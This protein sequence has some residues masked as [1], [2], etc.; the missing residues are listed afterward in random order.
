MSEIANRNTILIANEINSI[1]EQTH[2]IMIL[3]SIEIGKR[4]VEAKAML[5]HGD[6]GKWLD[7]SVNYS[8]RT[9]NNLMKLYEEYGKGQSLE[10][11]N[12]SQAIAKLNYTQAVAL[13]GLPS[14]ER[15]EFIENNDIEKMST[16]ELNAAVKEKKQLE[17]QLKEMEKVVEKEKK[18]KEEVQKKFNSFRE[19]AVKHQ[20][21]IDNLTKKLK[22]AEKSG[23]DK[24]IKD[25]NSI[26]EKKESE[27]AEHQKKIQKLEQMLKEKPIEAP[28]VVEIVPD[29]VQ[30]ELEE[31]RKKAFVN[32][33]DEK[34]MKFKV[35]FNN[36]G[37][38]FDT[39]LNALN[40]V[41]EPQVA[42]KLKNA[43]KGL[44]DKMQE[45]FKE[46]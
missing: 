22:E 12:I 9:A 4:L 20:D 10:E 30:K 18:E 26:L 43:V 3:S 27:L 21:D 7:E 25:L 44:I 13:L 15:E 2:K 39:L 1:K 14:D 42:E 38:N 5:P 17:K 19:E 33:S 11:G 35:H 37:D 36:L 46:V 24:S 41:D 6:W 29:N 34:V 40:E 31:L 32:N 28:A 45:H 8:Q 16:R 23:D